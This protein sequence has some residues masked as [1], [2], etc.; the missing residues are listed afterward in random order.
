MIEYFNNNMPAFWFT[1]G[2]TLL[3]LEAL[4]LGFS[5]GVVLFAGLGG[6]I[7]GGLQLTGVIPSTWLMGIASFGVCSTISTLLLWKPLMRLQN[8]EPERKD[9]S[10][11]LIGFKFRLEQD[12]ST[13]EPGSINYSGISWRVEIA[14]ES[15]ETALPE[16]TVVEVVSIDAGVFRVVKSLD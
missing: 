8:S 11:D 4:I 12:I 15:K 2:F 16:S 6:L 5:T 1:V 7:T 10:S 13:K 14:L 9:N 3:A